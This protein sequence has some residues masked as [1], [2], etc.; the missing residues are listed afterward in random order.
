MIFTAGGYL[1]DGL[2]LNDIQPALTDS[3]YWKKGDLFLSLRH[4]SLILLYR[5]S[6]GKIIWMIAMVVI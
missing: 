5:P 6:T 1:D 4:K 3:P 2:H